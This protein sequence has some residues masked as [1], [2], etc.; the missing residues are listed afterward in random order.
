MFPIPASL[1]MSP[2]WY[3]QSRASDGVHA[4]APKNALAHS[5]CCGPMG[6]QGF[7]LAHPVEAAATLREAQAA[8]TRARL[9]LDSL[10]QPRREGGDPLVYLGSSG[11]RRST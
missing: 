5:V 2:R 3:G 10:L 9:A 11:R 6:V 1:P 8:G 7:L 4:R